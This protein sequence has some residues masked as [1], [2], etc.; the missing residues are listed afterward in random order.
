MGV[1]QHWWATLCRRGAHHERLLPWLRRVG[2]LDG[3]SPGATDVTT[4]GNGVSARGMPPPHDLADTEV[5]RTCCIVGHL[6]AEDGF[7][8]AG[9][10]LWH[11]RRPGCGVGRFVRPD[12]GAAQPAT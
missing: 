7:T 11:C 4:A 9:D 12:P 1:E 2:R 8:S 6:E 5:Y 3:P 10:R